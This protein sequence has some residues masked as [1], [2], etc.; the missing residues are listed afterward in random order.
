[1]ISRK[2]AVPLSATASTQAIAA[3]APARTPPR[4]AP[5]TVFAARS[6]R[7]SLGSVR[8]RS[9]AVLMSPNLPRPRARSPVASPRLSRRDSHRLLLAREA[10][11]RRDLEVHRVRQVGL[12]RRQPQRRVGEADDPRE[13]VA[14]RDPAVGEDV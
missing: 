13:G 1:M 14:E 10:L 3:T 9:A 2:N 5:L 7:L 4:S 11:L 8:S 6:R 12:A